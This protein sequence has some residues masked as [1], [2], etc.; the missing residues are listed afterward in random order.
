[1]EKIDLEKKFQQLE[2][3]FSP[4]IVGQFNDQSL[5]ISKIKEEFVWHQHEDTDEVFLV[6]KG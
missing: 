4:S 2:D 6:V 1:M 3:V 5:K